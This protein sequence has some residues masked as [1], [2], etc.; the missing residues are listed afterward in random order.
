MNAAFLVALALLSAAPKSK[1]A[2][3]AAAPVHTFNGQ[4][5]VVVTD[6]TKEVAVSVSAGNTTTLA[7]PT[8]V[9]QTATVIFDSKYFGGKPKVVGQF[10]SFSPVKDIP[11]GES[12][13]LQLTLVDNTVLPPIM[14]STA[15]ATDVYVDV[16][17]SLEKKSSADSA[18]ALKVQLSEMQ[19][20]LDE[21]QQSAGERGAVKVGELVL[22]QDFH[23]QVAF[24][25]EKHPARELD[26]QSRLLVETHH[27]YRLFDVSYLVLT[28][29]NRDPDKLWVFDRAEV[30]T[31]GGNTSIDARVLD[32][33]QE[34]SQG[35]PPGVEAKLV[36]VYKTPEQSVD[37]LF[38]LKLLEKAGN[39][40]VELTDLKL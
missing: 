3:E 17:L 12:V 40:H 35:I 24:V 5:S 34:M 9:K 13:V 16:Q 2:K 1:V 26:K 37:H 15:S 7:F 11:Q 10:V 27:V 31:G 22:K 21:C 32:V 23:K 29:E 14:L 8:A 28:V 20:R 18:T 38:T 39:R 36:V 4:R 6:D 25:V 19:S 30:S 33:A